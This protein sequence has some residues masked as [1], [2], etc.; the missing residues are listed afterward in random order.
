MHRAWKEKLEL[1]ARTVEEE[2]ADEGG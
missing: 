1:E 2:L